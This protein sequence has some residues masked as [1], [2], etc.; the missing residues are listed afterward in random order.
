MGI[1]NGSW[2]YFES[3][4]NALKLELMDIQFVNILITNE[5]DTFKE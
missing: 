2:V 1:A 5:S 4:G 3:D